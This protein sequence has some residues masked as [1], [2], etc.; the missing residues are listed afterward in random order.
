[1][2]ISQIA[3]FLENRQGRLNDL[4]GAIK[5]ANVNIDSLNIAD[6]S[7][8]GIVRMITDDNEKALSV[9]KNAGFTALL[10]DLV[11]VEVDDKPGSLSE[12]VNTLDKAGINIEY[13][14]SYTVRKGTTLI[15]LRVD[16]INL[17]QEILEK[18]KMSR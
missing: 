6:T 12:T 11:A 13:V 2:L 7:D 17:A 9:L 8:F 14:Y 15:L 3:V 5:D 18:N 10:N 4:L 1:M 16:N